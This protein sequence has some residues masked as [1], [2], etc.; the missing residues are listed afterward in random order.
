[1]F[2]PWDTR[3]DMGEDQII[4]AEQRHQPIAGRELEA[5]FPFALTDHGTNGRR[6]MAHQRFLGVTVAR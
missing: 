5:L 3:G 1:M 6:G 4:P 2:R